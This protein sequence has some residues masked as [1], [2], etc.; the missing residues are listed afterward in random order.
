MAN[1][2]LAVQKNS[3]IITASASYVLL[4]NYST[5]HTCK[6]L[7]IGFLT[8]LA[9]TCFY[10]FISFSSPSYTVTP[11]EADFS[12]EPSSSTPRTRRPVRPTKDLPYKP[13]TDS[14][15]DPTP[16][17][18]KG[19]KVTPK[20]QKPTGG[21]Q[22]LHTVTPLVTLAAFFLSFLLHW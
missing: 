12:F 5:L 8:L 15:P 10:S 6:F 11:R 2:T 17:R 1:A 3:L 21:A 14:V 18:S 7:R 4:E 13:V 19:D 9:L 22:P 16:D 20:Q